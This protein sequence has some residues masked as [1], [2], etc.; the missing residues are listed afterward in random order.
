MRR[1]PSTRTVLALAAVV[2]LAGCGSSGDDSPEEVQADL[3]EELQAQL[4][5]DEEQADC[6]AEVLVDEIG[7]EELQD[8]DFT[9]QEPPTGMEEEFTA[10]ATIAIDTCDIDVSAIGG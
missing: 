9:A 3:A 5:L 7:A 1:T 10:A 4:A 6:F 8:I 2:V